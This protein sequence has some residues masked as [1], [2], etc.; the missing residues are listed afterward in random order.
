[1]IIKKD[2]NKNNNKNNNNG[3]NNDESGIIVVGGRDGGSMGRKA[4]MKERLIQIVSV[5]T[6]TGRYFEESIA[7]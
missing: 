4:L 6:Q 5:P 2:N 7:I 1:M 3:D